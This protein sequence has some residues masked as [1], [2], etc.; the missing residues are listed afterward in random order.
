YGPQ[1]STAWNQIA[2]WT[3]KM[4]AA[5]GAPAL[6]SYPEASPQVEAIM[7]TYDALPKSKS[8]GNTDPNTNKERANWI[9]AHPQEYTQM[10][11]YL[12]QAS[13]TSLIQNAAL[14]QFQG[15][16]PNQKLLKDIKDV[17]SYDIVTNPDGSLGLAGT[18]NAQPGAVASGSGGYTTS[19]R[20][21]HAFTNPDAYLL[22]PKDIYGRVH[23]S[24]LVKPAYFGP[25]KEAKPPKYI[26][27]PAPLRHS[28]ERRKPEVTVNKKRA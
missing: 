2:D 23:E 27:N 1:L 9:N 3:N 13:M 10:T 17:G 22:S 5:E 7:K 20:G 4:R 8:A 24:G 16:T 12:A 14:A 18:S 21:A 26:K 11:S 19:S 15:S 28:Q 6:L 25:L